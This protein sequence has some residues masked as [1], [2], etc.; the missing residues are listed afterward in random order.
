[1]SSNY[2]GLTRNPWP[3]TWSSSG[4]HPIVLDTELRGSLQSLSGVLGDRLTD[5]TGQRLNEGMIAYILNGYTVG[6]VTRTS[7]TYYKYN[8]LPGQSRNINTGEMPNSE[9]NWTLVSFS[10]NGVSEINTAGSS[11]GFSL[12]G[13][14]ITSIGTITLN[15]PTAEELKANLNIGNISS[16]NLSGN[17]NTVLAGDGTWIPQ[18]SSYVLPIASST[19][20]GGIKVGSGLSINPDGTLNVSATGL[21]AWQTFVVAGQGNL[22][23]SG[24][25]T[26]EI[27][28][29]NGIYISTSPT[30]T[31]NPQLVINASVS[32]N[33]D[34]G[35]PGS[36]Y[37]GVPFID[38]GGV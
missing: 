20:L 12:T 7:D 23:A 8:L 1:M 3:G 6:P 19:I 25:D 32:T 27:V 24:D 37:G 13:G 35:F 26:L 28:A 14:P 33:L 15:I 29:G 5:I 10:A 16:V 21:N 11:L 36:I 4:T 18:S 30:A 38:A 34:G 2:D 9:D 22:T 17:A 31:P